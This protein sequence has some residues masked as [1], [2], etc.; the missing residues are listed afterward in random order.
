MYQAQEP[1]TLEAKRSAFA[2]VCV[3]VQSGQLS[4]SGRVA[5]SG[6]ALDAD[7][8]AGETDQDRSEG[9]A[10]CRSDQI[11]NGRGGNSPRT[12]SG[13][14]G[15]DRATATADIAGGLTTAGCRFW[16]GS[17][18]ED[19]LCCCS[20]KIS[21]G[22]RWRAGMMSPER[23]NGS[24]DGRIKFAD[25]IRGN[26]MARNE[27]QRPARVAGASHM[28]NVGQMGNPGWKL[29]DVLRLANNS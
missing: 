17:A 10:P 8:V 6:A 1:G 26:K 15:A 16:N 2:A 21:C 9:G 7:D 3:G 29:S 11:S 5:P 19:G 25:T 22:T 4:A 28:G 27:V 20:V 12:V 18:M 14:S 23:E 13:D 24:W